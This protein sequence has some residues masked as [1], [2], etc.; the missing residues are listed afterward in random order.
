MGLD[1]RTLEN[2]AGRGDQVIENVERRTP[3]K[4][5]MPNKYRTP[6]YD[7]LG[8]VQERNYQYIM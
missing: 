3:N 1:T 6:N 2:S 4:R 7:W 8:I 5:R